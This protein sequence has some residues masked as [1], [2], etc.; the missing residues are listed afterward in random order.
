MMNVLVINKRYKGNEQSNYKF[1]RDVIERYG[2]EMQCHILQYNNDIENINQYDSNITIMKMPEKKCVGKLIWYKFTLPSIIKKLNISK[3]I[4]ING[5]L[6]KNYSIT[7]YS[8][9]TDIAFACDKKALSEYEKSLRKKIG[10]TQLHTKEYIVYSKYAQK[11][12]STLI[13]DKEKIKIIYPAASYNFMERSFNEKEIRKDIITS[14]EDFFLAKISNKDDEQFVK[15][16]RGFT[17]FKKWQKSNMKL[18]I[19]GLENGIGN[20]LKR[21]LASYKHNED[22]IILSEEHKDI[23]PEIL[24]AAYAFLLLTKNDADVVPVLETLQSYTLLV[25][26]E[27]PSI[28]EIAKDAY[29]KIETDS[30]ENIGATMINVYKNEEIRDIK[31]NEGGEIVQQYEYENSKNS[32]FKVIGS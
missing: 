8:I 31:I 13:N 23:Y 29:I 2:L 12:L 21:K 20:L 4:F 16:L 30:F 27:L 5:A 17:I 3:I 19:T 15:V 22:V 11:Q 10:K 28:K 32:F 26:Y 7:Q 25:S 1:V 9:F 24:S 6:I 14:G 18:L